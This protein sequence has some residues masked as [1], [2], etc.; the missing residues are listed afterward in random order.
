VSRALMISSTILC[1]SNPS[2]PPAALA[3]EIESVRAAFADRTER[4]LS[5]YRTT[6]APCSTCHA[7]FDAYGLVLQNFDLIGRYREQDERGRPI[8]ASTS[9]PASAGGADVRDAVELAQIVADNGSF[10]ACMTRN[11]MKYA[12][13]QGNVDLNDC[14]VRRATERVLASDRSFSSLIREIATSKTFLVRASGGAP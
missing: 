14:A 11:V 6:T 13:A 10:A 5:E 12:L 8:D 1:Q 2:A 7:T 4:E 3:E 9:L